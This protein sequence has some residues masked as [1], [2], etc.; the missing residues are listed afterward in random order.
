MLKLQSLNILSGTNKKNINI[1]SNKEAEGSLPLKVENVVRRADID[2]I[3]A[4]ALYS[5]QG[6]HGNLTCDLYAKVDKIKKWKDREKST[7][8][9]ETDFNNFDKFKNG[10]EPRIFL[11]QDEISDP[12]SQTKSELS[13]IKTKHTLE[14]LKREMIDSEY[15][16]RKN[17]QCLPPVCGRSPPCNCP[18][19]K[20]FAAKLRLRQNLNMENF[21]K[22]NSDI[23]LIIPSLQFKN[24]VI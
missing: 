19:D 20:V 15:T 6:L 9:R 18:Q 21:K 24:Y 23:L 2:C 5:N 13:N 12:L 16:E 7:K 22:F 8:S 3:K 4:D 1:F 11:E 14:D 17:M 10:G